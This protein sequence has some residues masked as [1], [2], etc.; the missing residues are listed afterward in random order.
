[1]ASV[2]QTRPHCVNQMG[3]THSKPLAP[4]HG[5]GMLCVNQLNQ[6]RHRGTP[7]LA[8]THLYW[9]SVAAAFTCCNFP[10]R[11]MLL[12]L[13]RNFFRTAS[14]AKLHNHVNQEPA[15]CC[16]YRYCCCYCYCWTCFY[17]VIT[18]CPFMSQN[19]LYGLQQSIAAAEVQHLYT[20]VKNYPNFDHFS[21]LCSPDIS[22]QNVTAQWVTFLA[23]CLG[24]S[25]IKSQT[26]DR[27]FLS[28]VGF[29]QSLRWIPEYFG[30]SQPW[31]LPLTP[32]SVSFFN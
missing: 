22:S 18:F 4:R 20:A 17:V 28:F 13:S 14:T 23:S 9:L 24:G 1:M 5:R 3:K 15:L 31:I 27:L 12:V 19:I 21:M 29:S 26:G 30:P 16:C 32:F 10:L 25:R 11:H 8:D 2:N 6:L 7:V